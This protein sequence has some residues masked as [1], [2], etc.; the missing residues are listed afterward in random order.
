MV[1]VNERTEDGHWQTI[2]RE[3]DVVLTKVSGPDPEGR[4]KWGLQYKGENIKLLSFSNAK[5]HGTP[6]IGEKLT[7]DMDWKI[8]ELYMPEKL[9]GKKEVIMRVITVAFEAW[10]WNFNKNNAHSVQVTFK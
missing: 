2:D 4:Y 10:G 1:F 6:K 5:T 3:N 9:Q 7:Y 8:R